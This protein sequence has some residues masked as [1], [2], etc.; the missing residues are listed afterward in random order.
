MCQERLAERAGLPW[1]YVGGIERGE[2]NPALDNINRLARA[3]GVSLNELFGP[4]RSTLAT[5]RRRAA[6]H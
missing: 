1:T 6:D 2:R 5:R 3:M 4:F